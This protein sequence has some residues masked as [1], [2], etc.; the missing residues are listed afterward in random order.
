MPH[1]C[2]TD[3][4][5]AGGKNP[6]RTFY[7]TRGPRDDYKNRNWPATSGGLQEMTDRTKT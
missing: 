4:S 5:T 1:D 3:Y 7:Y 2:E 6:S